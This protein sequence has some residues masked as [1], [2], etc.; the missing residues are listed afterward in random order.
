MEIKKILCPTDFSA[1]SERALTEAVGLAQTLGAKVKVIHVFQ[2][3]IGI[4]VE[5][6]PVSMEAA[7]RFIEEAHQQLRQSLEQLRERW[8][9]TCEIEVQLME[10]APY[11]SIV[12]ESKHTDMIVMATHGRSGFQRFVLGS[13]A[14][15]VVRMAE[16]P[17][18]TLPMTEEEKDKA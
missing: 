16:C 6:A 8:A 14:E 5:G 17:V 4:A 2:R 11:A 13:V 3:P 7:D 10:G 9:K 18:L 1:A 15:R 12:E